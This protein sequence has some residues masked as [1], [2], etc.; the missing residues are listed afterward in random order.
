MLI[1]T[2]T[3]VSLADSVPFCTVIP[4][5][6]LKATEETEASPDPVMRKVISVV[7]MAPRSGVIP[8]MTGPTAAPTGM[9]MTGL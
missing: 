2:S 1:F 3:A 8:V 5:C 7:P 9:L 4:V 6:G